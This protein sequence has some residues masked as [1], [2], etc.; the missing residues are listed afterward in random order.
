M[1][2]AEA[3]QFPR[4]ADGY[5]LALIASGFF[6]VQHATTQRGGDA[7]H[8]IEL[9]VADKGVPL[10]GQVRFILGRDHAGGRVVDA[11][12]IE[13][14]PD[15]LVPAGQRGL[16]EQQGAARGGR[17]GGGKYGDGELHDGLDQRNCRH[18]NALSAGRLK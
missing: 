6:L 15:N 10:L 5:S 9:M 4:R 17:M 18:D 13:K 12:L 16:G 11:V 1:Q 14:Q 7:H 3:G 8:A 2:L